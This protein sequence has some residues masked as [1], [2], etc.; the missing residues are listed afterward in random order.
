[1]VKITLNNKHKL[2]LK[3][4]KKQ[5]ESFDVLWGTVV[6]LYIHKK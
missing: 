3:I 5:L 1:M 4:K 6:M 2:P